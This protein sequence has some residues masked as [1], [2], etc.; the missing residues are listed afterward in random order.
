MSDF[1]ARF[2]RSI[3]RDRLTRSYARRGR[4][5]PQSVYVEMKRIKKC[6]F[7]GSKNE[8]APLEIHH[9]KSVCE[10]GSNERS[11]LVAL[12]RVCHEKEHEK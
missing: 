12:C 5:I 10:G 3:R 2:K 1:V 8:G 4:Y 11:N 7:C 9:K 6:E